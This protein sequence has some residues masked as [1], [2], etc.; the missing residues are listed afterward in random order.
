MITLR[1]RF[2]YTQSGK[3]V[4]FVMLIL[5]LVMILSACA[6]PPGL[7][8]ESLKEANELEIVWPPPPQEARIR[9]LTSISGPSDIGI[10]RSWLR[11]RLDSLLGESGHSVSMLRPYGI[12]AE[13]DTI[14]VTDPGISVVHI[15]NIKKNTYYQIRKYGE[16]RLASPIGI[17]GDKDALYVSD[18]V[19]RKVLVFD[20]EGNYIR[21]IVPPDKFIRPTGIAVHE[22]KIYVVD[23]LANKIFILDKNNGNLLTHFGRN[24]IAPGEFHYPTNIFIARD[25]NLYITDS[26]N[27]RI[28]IFDREGNFLSGFGR[29]G[30]AAGNFSK[31]KGVAVDSDGHIYV[32][33]AEFDNIQIF[34]RNGNL[35]LFFGNTG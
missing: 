34:D 3:N 12:F 24:G 13:D 1:L 29:H 26:L 32:A 11:K 21:E 17:T 19:L 27:F 23:T 15:F 18:S 14:C 28:Q 10:K 4:L 2:A 31:P 9:L 22:N 6:S 16:K 8:D 33:D 25:Y 5:L 20:K 7:V 30:D 35:L